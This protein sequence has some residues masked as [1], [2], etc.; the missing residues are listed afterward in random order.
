MKRLSELDQ[1][2][3]TDD[4]HIVERYGGN[5]HD[6]AGLFD[7]PVGLF[8][9]RVIAT[10]GDGWD[11]VSISAR[12]RC[13]TWDEMEHVKRLFFRPSEVAMQLHVR[14]E[15]HINNH[16]HTLHLWRCL[17]RPIPLPPKRMV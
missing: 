6:D 2:R 4:P 16:P 13:P 12:G 8:M 7:V 17:H 14:P 9:L 3:R 5:G 1:Y 15:D 10:T 11:H